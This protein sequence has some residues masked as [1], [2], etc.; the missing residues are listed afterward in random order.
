MK[1]FKIG[2]LFLAAVMAVGFSKAQSIEEG[3]QFLYY[4]KY[5][6]ARNTFQKLANAGNVE[7]T[8]WLG[9]TF[10]LPEDKDVATAKKLYQAYLQS[11][12]N[13]PLIMAGLGHA[14]LLEG[15]TQ[16][17]RSQFESAI[18][19]SGGKDVNVLNAV[20]VANGDFDVKAGDAAYAIDKLKQATN[21][22]AGKTAEIYT[23]LGDA[24]RKIP[25]GSNA[26]IAYDAALAINPRYA[27]AIYRKGRIYQ[28]QGNQQQDIFMQLYNQS[29]ATDPNYT[30]VYFTLYQYF[31]ETN[32]GRSAE[33]L[34]KYLNAKGADEPNQ[35]FF[36]AQMKYA[37][38]LFQ[39]AIAASQIC[40]NNS[41]GNPYP[42]IYGLIAY[43]AYKLN[44]SVTAKANFDLYFQKQKPEKIGP[45]DY[46]TY[47][48]VLLKFP[49][50]E[51]L[52]GTFIDK[53]VDLDS[54][55]DGKVALLKSVAVANEQRKQYKEAGE[56]YN[57]IL[58]IK[59]NPG[60]VDLYNAGYNF[61]R[62][63]EF[64]KAN[65]IFNTYIQKFPDETFGYYMIAR[66]NLKLDSFD[67]ANISLANHLKIANM[68]DML[69]DKQAERDRI[70]GSLRFLIEHYANERGLKD[71]AL[72]FSNKGV[73]LDPA[74]SDFVRMRDQITKLNLK[75]IPPPIVSIKPNG[76]RSAVFP[77]GT[78]FAVKP[79]GSWSKIE[80]K[81]VSN[82]NAQTG[83]TTIIE[84]AK[85]TIIKK[86]GTVSVL[87]PPK[88]P[89]KPPV[90][91]N[92]PKKR[93]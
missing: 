75:P 54:T 68:S 22:K 77:N 24:Y 92:P 88:A 52:A 43:S 63:G 4:E 55:I 35:C 27:R 74:D 51:S 44:D 40:I 48:E 86:D 9:Q 82:Y 25:D 80:G 30:P 34:D 76:E 46:K 28:T 31:Y 93:K 45:T 19:L 14:L 62:G 39:D 81:K 85:T 29:I 69:K 73:M 90:K 7:A 65:A 15:K 78:V 8:Y 26:L 49:G 16:E 79:D 33:Y 60:K 3:K 36:R 59:P 6:S 13:S 70:K 32:V 64:E 20:G 61:S 66:N 87:E 17:A 18:S 83:E 1:H 71:S 37:Q 2:V 72:F 41:G 5:I 57:K 23:N 12:P 89:G 11:S 58:M 56:Y 42:N 38:G 10:L 84:G 21:I 53:A 47:A 50:N 67:L 91:N